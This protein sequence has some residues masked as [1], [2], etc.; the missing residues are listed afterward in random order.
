MVQLH[1]FPRVLQTLLIRVQNQ[2]LQDLMSGKLS[3]MIH[4]RSHIHSSLRQ[5]IAPFSISLKKKSCL[6]RKAF[7]HMNYLFSSTRIVLT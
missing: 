3:E 6:L 1:C 4:P 7:L 2:I 5:F